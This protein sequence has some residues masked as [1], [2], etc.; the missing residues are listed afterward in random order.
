MTTCLRCDSEPPIASPH[1]RPHLGIDRQRTH[2]P[3]FGVEE[4]SVMAQPSIDEVPIMDLWAFKDRLA[5]RLES[6]LDVPTMQ[7]ALQ[8]ARER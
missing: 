2:A 6:V 3:G 5:V 8:I 1:L 4:G 7:A